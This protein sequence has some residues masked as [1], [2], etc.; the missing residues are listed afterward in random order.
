MNQ[1]KESNFLET[2]LN[3]LQILASDP[4]NSS[5]VF[6]S[7]GSG[8]TKILTD[9][10]LRLLLENVAPNKILCLT[11]TKVAATE[12][13]NRINSELS[14]WVIAN[15]QELLIKIFNL[16]GKKPFINELNKAR[17][18]LTKILDEEEKIK[19]QTIHSF[20]NSLL[21]IFPIEAKLNPNFELL[22]NSEEIL[23]LK[24]A[25]KQVLNEA[26]KD[27]NLRKIIT[28]IVSE[29]NEETIN[30]AVSKILN[31][32]E[33]IIKL[34][35]QNNNSIN[36]TIKTIYRLFNFNEISNEEELFNDFMNDFNFKEYNDF[37]TD[38]KQSN[39]KKNLEIAEKLKKFIDSPLLKNFVPFLQYAIH[40]KEDKV[41]KIS[42]KLDTKYQDFIHLQ[43]NKINTLIDKLSLIV[44]I[45]N[46]SNLIILADKIL[47]SYQKIK[48]DN[49][50][51]DYN[52]LIDRTN[53]LLKN[54]DFTDWVKKKLDSSFNHILV[55]ESQDTNI[56][57]WEIIKALTEDF[58]SGLS[59][60]NE[61]RTIFIVGDEKQSIY[62]FQGS[63]VN[64]TATVFDFFENK[65]QE[66]LNKIEMNIS[67]RSGSKILE[68]VDAVFSDEQRK[69][70]ISKISTFKKHIPNR[71]NHGY[72]AIWPKITSDFKENEKE[73]SINFNNKTDCDEKDKSILARSIAKN[74]KSWIDN[75]REI[76]DLKKEIKYSDIMVLIKN[77]TNGLAKEINK[78]FNYYNIPFTTIAKIKFNES[79]LIQDI[80]SVAK[81][82]LLPEDDLNLACLLK[83]C[84]FNV[85]EE[86][87]LNFCIIKNQQ[88]QSLYNSINNDLIKSRLN[89]I[90]ESS[91]K[92]N[93]FEFFYNII[94]TD[95]NY[96]KLLS[97]FGYEAIELIDSFL[98]NVL[99][100]SKK[101]SLFIQKYIEHIEKHNPEI[102]S[103]S[104]ENNK[105][106]I[107]TI[108]SS[109]GLEAPIVII[110]D[111]N[112]QLNKS[113]NAKEKIF[114]INEIPIWTANNF[115]KSRIIQKYKTDK[116]KEDMD[117]YLRLLYVAM[118]RARDELYIGSFGRNEDKNC[119][120]EIIYES[121]KDI[122]DYISIDDFINI[123]ISE[124]KNFDN[125]EKENIAIDA[126]NIINQNIYNQTEKNLIIE[127]F[128]NTEI[129]NKEQIKGKIIHKILEFFGQNH[130][131]QKTWLISIAK[132][133]IENNSSLSLE[134]KKEIFNL[135]N[136][137]IY[138]DQFN[139]IFKGNIKCETEI[140]YNGA[141]GR[142]DLISEQQDRI[143]IVDYKSDESLPSKI[144]EQYQQ[145]L[146]RY[147]MIAKN[148]YKDKDIIVAIFWI[149]FLKMQEV[150]QSTSD[151]V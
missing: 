70:S 40:T 122:A 148:I 11:F 119:W 71:K 144:P 1:I 150:F 42:G 74:I 107:T 149:R 92:Q 78:Y 82:A 93:C 95:N 114:W 62:S 32:K 69:N 143:L 91:Q 10:V 34:K 112:H 18:L 132:K 48:N 94:Q 44:I 26:D 142:V 108:H 46:T 45:K 89:K 86:D 129:I 106:K 140:S 101:H 137:F 121:L 136:D 68:A 66:K 151:K 79:L 38:L 87:L 141:F 113:E 51:I 7:A 43:S 21:K 19:I 76:K 97:Y 96:D 138:S 88:E 61:N 58:Y 116:I 15:D 117:E 27:N 16:T 28:E 37:I 84:F 133:I 120:Y 67:Y 8:K 102:S 57:Q 85:S 99:E 73:W 145:Q 65:L 12:M 60:N 30:D 54:P 31:K 49:S 6:A 147:A 115:Q 118:T 125:E 103:S 127:D 100:F 53:N 4:N 25:Y 75:K 47:Q 72:I 50:L 2:N 24:K 20:C 135:A 146:N 39:S 77:K 111:C 64:I 139:K 104:A 109:K 5:W 90:I 17:T 83:S 59:A 56:Q 128:Q 33:N 9:R 134:E 131:Q 126:N 23:L 110:P 123:E 35:Q 105:V 3:N 98:L 41:R 130:Q 29:I 80:V 52:D 14:K 63:D 22:E 55:D 36:E 124:S 81:F 13:Y